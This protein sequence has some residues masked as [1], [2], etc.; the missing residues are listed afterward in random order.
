MGVPVVTL[1]GDRHAGRVGASLLTQ[2]GLTDLIADS[3]EEYVEIAAALG[4]RS[5]AAQRPAPFAAAAH[6]GVAAVRCSGI[7]PQDRKRLPHHVAA[8]GCEQ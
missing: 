2:V 6:G 5:R 8:L 4:R 3:V 7:C 1:R